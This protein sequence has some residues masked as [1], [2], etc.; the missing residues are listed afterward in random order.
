MVSR[1]TVVWFESLLAE[2]RAESVKLETQA[3]ITPQGGVASIL[4]PGGR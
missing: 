1:K 3:L 4:P 2:D